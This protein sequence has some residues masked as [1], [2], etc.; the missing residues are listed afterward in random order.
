MFDFC[1][2]ALEKVLLTL[3]KY[4]QN[5]A[6][7]SAKKLTRQLICV[8]GCGGDRDRLKRP[9]MAEI[10]EKY[11]SFII[12]T[13]D[14]SRFENPDQIFQDILTGLSS[15]KN[16]ENKNYINKSNNYKIIPSRKLAIQAAVQLAN[17]G[18]II[19]LAG[20]GHE[21][22]LDIQ[23]EKIPFDERDFLT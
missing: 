14:N 11:A 23:G 3:E 12:I 22:Y 21:T 19:L 6:Q 10:A 18:D 20:K 15:Y 2:D 1:P 4:I 7:N 9:K 17:P 16:Q 5:P 8:F 13:E